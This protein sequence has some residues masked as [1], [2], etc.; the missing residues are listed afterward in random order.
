MWSQFV[1]TQ[2]KKGNKQLNIKQ[3][4]QKKHKKHKMMVLGQV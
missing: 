1:T 4:C 2:P 3:K